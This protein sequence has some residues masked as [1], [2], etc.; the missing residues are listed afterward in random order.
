MTLAI[1]IDIGGTKTAIGVLNREGKLLSKVIIPTDQSVAPNIMMD[2]INT[3]MQQL[4]NDLNISKKEIQGIGVGAPGPIDTKL[5]KIVCPPNLPGWNDFKLVEDLG[6]RVGLEVKLE[7]DASLAGLAEM[8]IGTAKEEKDFLYMTISTG[9][10]AGIIINGSLVAGSTGNAGE[11]GHM[12][13]DPSYGTCK[14][15]QKGCLEW[16]A[17]GTAIARQGTDLLKKDVTTEEVFKMYFNKDVQIVEMVND[18]FDR[19][20]MACV[21]LINLLDINL[22]VLGG[23]VSKVGQPMISS[24]EKYIQNYA[25]NPKARETKIKQASLGGDVGII[26]AGALILRQ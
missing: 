3:N 8:W 26:G 20:G 6:R 18:I 10:G 9:I 15:G 21:S 2:R 14:C 12:V 16:I 19:L 5:G 13:V 11:V 4:I 17:S 7:N 23:G 25:L 22:L 1:G 24:I